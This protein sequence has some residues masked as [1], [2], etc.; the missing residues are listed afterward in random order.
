MTEKN[1]SVTILNDLVTIC[2][3]A[4]KGFRDAAQEVRDKSIQELLLAHARQMGQFGK[5]LEAHVVRLGGE[6]S[7]HGSVAGTLHRS[8]MDFRSVL[9]LHDTKLVLTECERGENAIISHYENA[10]EKPLP[11]DVKE[12]LE[13]QFVEILVTRNHLREI[14]TQGSKDP[15]KKYNP[16][17]H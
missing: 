14:E 1:A 3:D 13:K 10:M 15:K 4:E 11:Q 7:H 17:F 5:E 8:W 12:I 16:L 6:P 9:N 2:N